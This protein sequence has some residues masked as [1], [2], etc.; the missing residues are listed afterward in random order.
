LKKKDGMIRKKKYRV[1]E[2]KRIDGERDVRY[3]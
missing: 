3:S 2:Y 1:R